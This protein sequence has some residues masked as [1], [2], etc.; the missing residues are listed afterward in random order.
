MLA[1]VLL[2]GY[3]NYRS[4]GVMP[5]G[6]QLTAMIFE[7]AMRAYESGGPRELAAR[8]QQLERYIPGRRYLTNSEGRDLATSEDRSAILLRIGSDW[9]SPKFIQGHVIVGSRSADNRY[10]LISVLPP[11]YQILPYISFYILLLLAVGMVCWALAMSIASPLR[12]LV[13]AVDR[14]GRG[15]LSVRVDSRRRDEIG[16]LGKAFDQMA[17]R[18]ETLLASERRMMQDISH[19]LRSPLARLSFAVELVKADPDDPSV[20][21]LKKEVDRLNQLVNTLLEM[22]RAEQDPSCGDMV[23]VRLDVV[24]NEVVEICRLDAAARGCR[25]ELESDQN[26]SILGNAELLRRA[27]ENI[28]KNAIRYTPEGFSVDVNLSVQSGKVRVEIR[29][30]GPGVPEEHLAKIFQPFFRVDDSRNDS[31]GGVG[32][33]LAIA[34][35]AIGVHHGRLTAVN[36][37]PGL[38]VQVELA[39]IGEMNYS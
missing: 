7:E 1:F 3:I 35:R 30:Y 13:R 16:E 5:T 24:L 37:H 12:N 8:L 18:I 31:T 39:I 9:D 21:R 17:E 36:A 11:P 14:F 2:S 19:E 10:R 25:I 15:D 20:L 33:G 22:T 29:D 27:F 4:G 38:K 23:Q 32:L 26:V 6:P 28:V 34:R